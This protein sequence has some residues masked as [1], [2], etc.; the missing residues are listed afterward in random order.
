[1]HLLFTTTY[2]LPYISGLTIYVVRLSQELLK[3]GYE[4]EILTSRHDKKLPSREITEG[5]KI[6]RTPFLCRLS[7]G[8]LLPLYPYH[9]FQAVSKAD[10]VILNL[11]QF[12]SFVTAIVAKILKKRVFCIYNCEVYL[13]KN[14]TNFIV[15]K[16]S[17]AAHWLTLSLAD[18]IIAYTKDYAQNSRL[19]PYFKDKILT[20]YPPMPQPKEDKKLTKELKKMLPDGGYVIGVAAR[21]ATEKG[22]ENL[23]EAIPYLSKK[24]DKNFTIFFAGPEK[25]VGEDGYYKEIMARIKK[26]KNYLRFAGTIDYAKM[27]SFYSLLDVLVLPSVNSTEAF[28]MVQVEAMMCGVPVVATDLPGV[29]VPIQVTGMGKIVPVKNSKKLTEAM[30]EVLLN[31]KKYIKSSGLI[32]KEFTIDKTVDFYEKLFSKNN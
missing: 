7:K 25:P 12:E 14:L 30:A 17:I 9:V 3:R 13:P 5:V 32:R 23:L 2:Y 6:T 11:P 29:R 24:L 27:G 15:E 28:G 1:M 22:I 10:A 20:V 16:T 21:L 26:Y 4:V 8:F 19:L 31:K 18:K